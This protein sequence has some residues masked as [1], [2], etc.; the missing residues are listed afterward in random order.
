VNDLTSTPLSFTRGPDWT[1]RITLAPLTNQQSHVDG[2]LSDDEHHWLTMRAEGGFSLVMTCAS[3]VSAAG[4]GFPGQLGCWSDAHLAGLTRL[5]D[6]IRAKGSVSSVQLHHAGRRSPADL[7]GIQPVCAFDDPETG[8]RALTV[9]DINR[10]IDDFVAGGV[11]A[12]KAGFD[13][14]EIHGAHGYLVCQFLD[15][16]NNRRDDGWGGDA[17][18]RARF[19]H[20]IIDGLRAATPTDFQIGVRLSPERFGINTLESR[21][22]VGALMASGKLDYVDLSLWDTFKV[23]AD[24]ALQERTLFGWFSDLPRHGTRLGVA[25][26]IG[27][28][29]AVT[30]AMDAGADFVMIGRAAVLH[31]DFARLALADPAF[32]AAALPVTRAHLAKEGL[33]PSFI[34]YMAEWKG[35]VA[36]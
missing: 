18:G 1:H 31:H 30:R 26:R 35:F 17:I 4:Q 7:I 3:H 14:V 36:D 20:A 6:D 19:L 5:A 27:S 9:D 12:A 29:A 34:D 11:R 15:A 33:G 28:S 22:L 2:T 25:G 13:G 21:D 23:P 24:P 32:T 8:A 10:A 16:E